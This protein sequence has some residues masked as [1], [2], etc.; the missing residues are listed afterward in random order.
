[1]INIYN[2]SETAIIVVHEI[3]GINQHMKNICQSLSEKDFDV[4][5]PNLLKQ[6]APFDYSQEEIAYRNFM[7]NIGFANASN[8]MKRLL[9]KI[10]G[11][12]KK[13]YLVGY[14]IGA[15]IAWLCSEEEGISGIVGYYGSRIRNYLEINP[16]CPTMLFFPEKEQS[17]NVDELI[18]DLEEKNILVH[19]FK[20]QHGFCDQYSPKYNEI[21]TQATFNIMIDFFQNHQTSK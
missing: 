10:K 14:S 3:Y 21:S 8:E 6:E 13:T 20:G 11:K 4:I 12:Y 17:F 19:K 18:F 7:E 5:C 16:L 2:N 9:L 15:T 1:M